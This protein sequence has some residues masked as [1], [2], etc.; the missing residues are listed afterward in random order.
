MDKKLAKLIC[1]IDDEA[2]FRESYS[3]RAMYGE[4]TCAFVTPKSPIDLLVLVI[5]ALRDEYIDLE[6]LQ[7]I[8]KLRMR[9]DSM[10]YDTV[11]Y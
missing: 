9:T 5:E 2:R 6:D 11:Y 4:E 3:G 7:A 8:K 1:E 10:G